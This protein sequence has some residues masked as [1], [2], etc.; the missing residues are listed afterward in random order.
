MLARLI[1]VLTACIVFPGLLSTVGVLN[2][3]CGP[4]LCLDLVGSEICPELFELGGVAFDVEWVIDDEKIL[5]VALAGLESPVEAACEQEST[6]HN[7][8]LVV[9][10]VLSGAISAHRDSFVSQ[11]LAI[12]APVSHAFVVSDDANLDSLAVNVLDGSGEDVI[13]EVEDADEKGL[14][15]HLDVSLELVHVV[16][17]GEEEGVHVARLRAHE[18]L[19]DLSHVLA[20]VRKDVFII[21]VLHLA[22]GNFKEYIQSLIDS[23]AL[24]TARH[25]GDNTA[26]GV[27]VRLVGRHICTL[28][29]LLRDSVVRALECLGLL[30]AIGFNH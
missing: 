22:G 11:R 1:L 4:L 23:G 20:Q 19:V 24:V 14:L 2:G 9:H 16:E 10:V 8:E 18:I 25:L 30:R 27:Q 12:V 21:I 29:E 15:G 28:G 17:V 3:A 5:L 7:H 26:Q 6:I 13:S